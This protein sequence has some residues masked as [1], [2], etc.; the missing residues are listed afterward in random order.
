V[1]AD[2]LREALRDRY[3]FERELGRGGMATV[4]LV[5][6]LRHDRPVALKV[7]H[8]E[9][10]AT[11]GPE[12]FQREIRLAARLQHPH[13]LTV[14]DSG[15]TAGRLWFTMP[16][17]EGES[18][19]DRLRRERQLPVEAAIRIAIEAARGLE[20]AHQHGVVHRDI[21]PENILITQDGSTLV[22]D[23]GIARALGGDDGLT[24]TGLAI[25][26]PAY[27][28]PEQAAGDRAIDPRTD[29]YSLA[30]V[31]YEM[32]S[33]Q[34]PWTGAT[35]QVMI[36]R[37]LSE[38]APSARAVRPSVPGQVDEAIRKAL[39]PVAADRFGSMGEFVQA[40]QVTAT[41]GTPVATPVAPAPESRPAAAA[42]SV[43]RRRVPIAALTLVLGLLIG[44][45]V[46]FA[47]RRNHPGDSGGS[48]GRVVAVLPFENLGDSADV[49]F[50]DGVADEVRTKLTQVSG[51]VVIARSSSIQYRGTTKRPTEI[52]RE[53]GA[54][55]LLTGTVRWEKAAGA[56]SRVRVS[57]ELVEARPGEA[58][59][60]RW[61]QQFD[62]S[63]TNVFQ[64][65][66]EIATK[67]ADALNVELADSVRSGLAER[68][69]AN[70]EAYD[71]FLKGEAATSAMSSND[72][73]SLRRGLP[74]YQR[75]VELDPE[76]VPAWAR[77]ANIYSDL[78][79]N[80][81][82][83][84]E[85][86][87]QAREAVE[88]ARRLGPDRPEAIH[89]Q[90]IYQRDVLKDPARALE[91]F[92]R[93]LK[94]APSNVDLIGG[95]ASI[96]FARG[97]WEQSVSHLQRA[98]A[99]DPRSPPATRRLVYALISLRRYPEA[100]AAQARALALA[101]SDLST[102]QYGAMLAL[103]QGDRAGAER[104]ARTPPPG[105]KP[106][107][108]AYYFA[109]YEE[110]GWLLDSDQQRAVLELGPDAFGDD[111]APWATVLWQLYTMRGQPALAR[112][113]ADS[114][115]MA[116]EQHIAAEPNDPQQYAFL[117]VALA[118]LGRKDEAIRAA[119]HATELAPIAKDGFLG[120]YVQMLLARVHMMVGNRDKAIELLREPVT[121][122]NNVSKAWLRVDPTWDPLRKY[123]AFQQLVGSD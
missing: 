99:L 93:G 32:L 64:V 73:G 28:S 117:G 61:G 89:A 72:P 25:G 59:R 1:S 4:Y 78:Y 21:K 115:R 114:A 31:L 58:E 107:E 123:P 105:V 70:L 10:A 17:V 92:E 30:A 75:A 11:L 8:P 52:A 36:A 18:L 53:L 47:W 88:R 46:L 98:A 71:A 108:Q 121:V 77:L 106:I 60:T 44:A 119:T 97:N 94:L 13:V 74:H 23:F 87:E 54:D 102:I 116:Y 91:T 82:P 9:L 84:P 90:G 45:G 5:Q 14:L 120:P 96:G 122:P 19:R 85:L 101:P 12:R 104:V 35:A 100:E 86:A 42:A 41:R 81:A 33:G 6:D 111:R 68:P 51:L 83:T 55:Y 79:S 49:Y 118:A 62:A 80:I 2:S 67:V 39:A 26:T 112:A 37:R 20:Y 3:A 38:P 40:L 66:A 50:S 76:F 113:Y 43:T 27:M 56:A 110:L 69:T 29:Q 109:R 95:I 57:P 103:A 22:A 24:Q 15:E 16:Y 7:L 63:L 34:A 48:G 65:Q